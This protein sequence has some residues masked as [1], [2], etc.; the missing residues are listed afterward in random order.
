MYVTI[1]IEM[2]ETVKLMAT[3]VDVVN[4]I[5]GIYGLGISNYIILLRSKNT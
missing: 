2:A 4:L 5:M 3:P 1:P